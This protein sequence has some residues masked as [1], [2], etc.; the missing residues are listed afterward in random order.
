MSVSSPIRSY[1]T[2]GFCVHGM[3]TAPGYDEHVVLLRQWPYGEFISDA[4]TC[5][6]H[7]VYEP[8]SQLAAKS[9][10]LTLCQAHS[11]AMERT[12]KEADPKRVARNLMFL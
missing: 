7:L 4:S 5:V 2:R 9:H 6:S 10:K 11:F 8:S 1:I 3:P 12:V